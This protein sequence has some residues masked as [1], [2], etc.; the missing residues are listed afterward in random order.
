MSNA[1]NA[2]LRFL[3]PLDAGFTDDLRPLVDL[4]FEVNTE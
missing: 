4:A 1:L 3:L 2:V